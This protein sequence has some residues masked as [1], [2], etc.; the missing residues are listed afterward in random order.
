MPLKCEPEY[1]AGTCDRK[2]KATPGVV[3]SS[4]AWVVLIFWKVI[5]WGRGGG[6][7]RFGFSVE[8][9]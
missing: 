9:R 2:E 3:N 4:A 5:S 8:A 6:Q 1:G 7:E